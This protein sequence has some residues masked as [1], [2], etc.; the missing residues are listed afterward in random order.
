MVSHTGVHLLLLAGAAKRDRLVP[1]VCAGQICCCYA[2]CYPVL[3]LALL[4]LRLRRCERDV[5]APQ[6]ELISVL[7]L[8]QLLC[9]LEAERARDMVMGNTNPTNQ[10]QLHIFITRPERNFP[11]PPLR[12]NVGLDPA[13]LHYAPFTPDLLLEVQCRTASFCAVP[14]HCDSDCSISQQ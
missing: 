12:E 13:L 5:S 9:E 6:Y 2:C 10:I 14:C 3:I 7:R 8:L 1:V 4:I 11:T